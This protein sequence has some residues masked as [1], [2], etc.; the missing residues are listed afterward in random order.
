MT[1]WKAKLSTS[2]I[3]TIN[4]I[5]ETQWNRIFDDNFIESYGYHKT[6]E[7]SNLKEFAIFY[8][9]VKRGE[10][11]VAIAPFFIMD[12]SL[13]TLIRGWLQK[14]IFNLQKIFKRFLKM[15]ILFV[16]LPTAE[17]LYLGISKE[18][19]Y[20]EILDL[21]IKEIHEFQK[22]NKINTLLFYNL[23]DKHRGLKGYLTK[24]EF[25]GMENF[26]N[27]LMDINVGSVEEYIKSLG[28][29]TRKDLRRKI[30][31]SESLTTLET[32]IIDNVNGCVDDIYRLYTNSFNDSNV[33]FE[34]L[35]P[36]LFLNICRN[37]P[38]IAKYFITRENGKMIAFNLCFIK[39]DTCID[40]IIGLDYAYAHKYHLYYT[41]FLHNIGWC[42]KNGIRYYQPGQGDYD[43][44][45]RLGAE[46]LPL[47]IYVKTFNPILNFFM[48]LIITLV[49]PK[50]FD[51]VLRNISKY[52]KVS[53]G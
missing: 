10:N 7:E 19:N 40:K 17:H 45:I 23:T 21:I 52:R 33:R 9:T 30:R 8:L 39:G 15:R 51:P 49:E 34:V 29:S 28:S 42:I 25:L 50:Q 26:P 14:F 37:M 31:K 38:G 36:E 4:D 1:D 13:T 47:Y 41:T 22:R 20:E 46:L 27:S 12:F 11:I 3:Q 48:K 43:A 53:A 16:G 5:P 6:I 18:E 2:L 35:T 24:K 44:K 32:E